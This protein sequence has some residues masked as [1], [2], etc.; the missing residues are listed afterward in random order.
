MK[1]LTEAEINKLIRKVEAQTK[2]GKKI[3]EAISIVSIDLDSFYEKKAVLGFDIYQYSQFEKFQQT[4]I[5]HLFRKL[6]EIT[7][8]NCFTHEPYIFQKTSEKKIKENF[9]DSGDG[10]FLIFE[11]P[12]HALIFAIYFESNIKRYN[13]GHNSTEKIKNIVGEINLR[14]SLTHDDLYKTSNN[15]YGS[16][17]I[18][19]ARIMS[20]D[21]LNRFLL[22]KNSYTW[23]NKFIN[24][25]ETIQ[26]IDFEKDD[27]EEI[28]V[29]A[30]YTEIEDEETE[31]SLLFGKSANSIINSDIMHIGEIKS[32]LDTI[33]IYSSHIQANLQTKGKAGFNKIT[34]SLGNLNSNGISN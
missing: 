4:L 9:I 16:A 3:E 15:Y 27:H 24:G 18:T 26:L 2:D 19:N 17:I 11:T 6:M 32:K 14:Y 33:D 10:G 7:I 13:S 25:I 30:G 29:F 1:K 12:F 20:K 21:K 22:D 23:F 8:R 28:K 34:I 31:R 5:P